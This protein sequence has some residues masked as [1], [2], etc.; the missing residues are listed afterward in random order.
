MGKR[1]F[2]KEPFADPVQARRLQACLAGGMSRT[3]IAKRFGVEL[4]A[5]RE[6]IE[7]LGLDK[8]KA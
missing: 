6:A 3:T 7:K 8:A 1:G 4:D 5:L 2:E